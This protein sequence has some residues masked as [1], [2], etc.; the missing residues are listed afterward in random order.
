MKTSVSIR[1]SA[2]GPLV[3]RRHCDLRVSTERQRQRQGRIGAVTEPPVPSERSDGPSTWGPAGFVPRPPS[4]REVCHDHHRGIDDSSSSTTLRWSI[5]NI[6]RSA[7][8]SMATVWLPGPLGTQPDHMNLP[9]EPGEVTDID[10]DDGVNAVDEHG[11][12]HVGVVNLLSR[13][14]DLVEQ[15]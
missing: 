6:W 14:F 5:L 9:V 3:A 11:G 10:G 2:T 4:T 8:S 15:L 7:D 12:Y 1:R 13:A